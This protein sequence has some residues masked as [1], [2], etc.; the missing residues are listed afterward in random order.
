MA[1]NPERRRHQR[2]KAFPGQR[3]LI[4]NYQ[5]EGGTSVMGAKV[6]DFS[7]AGMSVEL[8]GLLP[9]GLSVEIVGEIEGPTGSQPLRRRGFVRRCSAVGD[10]TYV[11]GLS[12]RTIVDA[13]GPREGA[14]EGESADYYEVLQL[15][16]NAN[17]D[18]IQRVFRIL[19]KRYHPDNMETG[20]PELFRE[21]VEAAHVLT[22]PKLR[23]AYDARLSAQNQNRFKIFE[24]WQ[25][26]RGVEAEKR[27]RKGVLALLY[28]RRLTEPNRP[29]LSMRELEEMLDCPREHLEFT[30]W[31]LKES[32]WIKTAD[33]GRYEITLQG[34]VSAEADE[35]KYPMRPAVARLTAAREEEEP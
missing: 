34:V 33:N 17:I 6:L 15:S 10:G 12:F 3:D 32:K 11:A 8:A 25:T 30:M 23:A 35:E 13:S 7:E 26:S 31:F 22:D 20:N 21:A 29:T 27:K 9:M 28:G 16:R 14:Q 18:T 5:S 24:T 2:T 4:I 1:Q 19:A